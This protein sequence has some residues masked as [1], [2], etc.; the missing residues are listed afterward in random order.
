MVSAKPAPDGFVPAENPHVNDAADES[1][2]IHK[3][4]NLKICDRST[5]AEEGPGGSPD[6]M[7]I[8]RQFKR[9]DISGGGPGQMDNNSAQTIAAVRSHTDDPL[10]MLARI[11]GLETQRPETPFD[12]TANFIVDSEPNLSELKFE[13]DDV[14]DW[15]ESLAVRRR[16]FE[17]WRKNRTR[18]IAGKR[19]SKGPIRNKIGGVSRHRHNALRH[20]E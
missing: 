10:T 14:D 19:L 16:A 2:V 17:K 7:F 20:L 9:L 5:P 6:P 4:K 12:L 11:F 1:A 18:R 8:T 13:V 3:F 15:T